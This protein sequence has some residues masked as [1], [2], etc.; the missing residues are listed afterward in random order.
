[1]TGHA[2]R[3]GR[4]VCLEPEDALCRAKWD[5]RTCDCEYL[6]CIDRNP[7]G[8]WTHAAYDPS[9]DDDVVHTAVG[10]YPQGECNTAT[11]L[12]ESLSESGPA[13]TWAAGLYF[14]DGL[15]DGLIDVEWD[16][17]NYLWDYTEPRVI[18]RVIALCAVARWVDDHDYDWEATA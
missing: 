4:A 9:I 13:E 6:S 3:D 7:D 8:T 5:H 10:A 11:W 16:G 14:L 17:D 15:P 12:N 18:G 1:M 2:I